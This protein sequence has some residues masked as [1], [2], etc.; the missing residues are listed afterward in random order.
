[1]LSTERYNVNG[2]AWSSGGNYYAYDPESHLISMNRGAVTLLYDAFGNL[3]ASTGST[4]NSYLYRGEQ[5][6]SDLGMYYLR[7][8][9]YNPVTGRFLSRDPEDGY[10]KDPVSLH[11]Y[12]YANGDP[13]NLIDPRGRAAILQF[14]FTTPDVSTDTEIAAAAL[15]HGAAQWVAV[16]QLYTGIAYLTVQDILLEVAAAETTGLLIKLIA[17]EAIGA[18]VAEFISNENNTEL[19]KF[20]VG[21][22]FAHGCY[23]Y[24]EPYPF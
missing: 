19:Q 9:W 20:I 18:G 23:G 3:I 22:I 2:D 14:I 11:K 13:V 24:I 17:C 16:A 15:M 7:A 6:D 8:R 21:E 10:V 1:M 12:L 5:Y 4:P